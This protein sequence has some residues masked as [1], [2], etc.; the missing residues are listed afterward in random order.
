MHTLLN[1]LKVRHCKTTQ[2]HRHFSLPFLFCSFLHS[3]SSHGHWLGCILEQR[4]T[5]LQGHAWSPPLTGGCCK[6][7]VAGGWQSRCCCCLY[8]HTYTLLHS[9]LVQ[10][11]LRVKEVKATQ[12]TLGKKWNKKCLWLAKHIPIHEMK[13]QIK[14]ECES[15][16]LKILSQKD[17]LFAGKSKGASKLHM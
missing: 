3:F 16:F 5:D 10:P 9:R 15:L 7:C 12:I 17:Y 8:L 13:P 11:G 4:R 6:G 1:L 14:S 2:W